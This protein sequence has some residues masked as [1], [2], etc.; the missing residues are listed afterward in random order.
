[1]NLDSLLAILCAEQRETNRLLRAV[2]ER[3]GSTSK[4]LRHGDR[5]ALRRLLPVLAE[6]FAG[7]RFGAWEVLDVAE[8]DTGIEGR[9]VKLAIGTLDARALG[10]LFDR[11]AD[12]DIKG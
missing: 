11:G 2:L 1:M 12:R 8:N 7:V 3:G 10:R 6:T 5:E 9:N 4:A